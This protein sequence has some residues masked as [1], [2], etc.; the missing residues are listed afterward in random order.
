MVVAYNMGE[1]HEIRPIVRSSAA[2]RAVWAVTFGLTVLAD[3]TVAVQV[4]MM[5]ASILYI[6]KVAETTSVEPIT[7]DEVAHGEAHSLKDEDIPP[8][9]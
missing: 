7:P 3:L 4:G 6:H 8:Y 1:W 9:V 5:L 2:D